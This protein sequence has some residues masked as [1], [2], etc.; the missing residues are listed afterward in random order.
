MIDAATLANRIA[1]LRAQEETAA[2]VAQTPLSATLADAELLLLADAE[3]ALQER[4]RG[5]AHRAYLAAR[6]LPG[7][8]WQ[9]LDASWSGVAWEL[10]RA[11]ELPDMMHS[12]HPV[13]RGALAGALR[14]LLRAREHFDAAVPRVSEADR[15]ASQP[16]PTAVHAHRLSTR[17]GPHPLE[18]TF[19]PSEGAEA[20]EVVPAAKA[21]RGAA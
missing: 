11:A 19:A 7:C 9:A 16:V 2:V 3:P 8:D 12:S 4:L 10:R 13:A 6:A 17:G 14:A 15:L 20:V 1:A 5:E 18:P 21:R